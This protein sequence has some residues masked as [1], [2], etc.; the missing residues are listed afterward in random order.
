VTDPLAVPSLPPPTVYGGSSAVVLSGGGARG[1]YEAGVLRYLFG[2]FAARHGAP[3]FDIISGTSVGAINGAYLGGV[4]HEP[5]EG[6]ARLTR[7]WSE[8]ELDHVL[9]F[10]VLQAAKLPRV[11]FGGRQGAGLFDVSPLIR[12]VSENMRWPD[13]ARNVRKGRLSAVTVSATHVATGRPWCFVDRAPGVP[14]PMRL[15]PTMTVK[16]ERIGP[17]HVLASAAIPVLFPPVSVGDDLFVDG[18]L[19]L[20]TPISPPL[21]LGAR[22]LL[23]IGLTAA[24]GSP[25]QP[26]FEAG[27]YPG[28]AF[29]LGKVLNA[30]LLDRVST[31]FYELERVNRMID[32]GIAIYGEAFV[33]RMNERAE[34][35]GRPLRHRVHALLIHPSEDIGRLASA[36]LAAHRARFGK[37][38]GRSLLK[39]LDLGEGADADLVSYLLFDGAFARQLMDLGERDARRQEDHLARFFWGPTR[40]GK[41]VDEVR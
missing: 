23:V 30:F 29:L 39:L 2:E 13:L 22:R 41:A 40:A 38:L 19:R 33:D 12:I 28:I 32:D 7:L 16:A 26:A 9:G 14:L 1:A 15:P 6:I 25:V 3:S 31:D 34:A 37:L 8:L 21:Q 17:H 27:V 18:G 5:V 35:E 11:L 20:N 36:H 4:A 24:W 10:G